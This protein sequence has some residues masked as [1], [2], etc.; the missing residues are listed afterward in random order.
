[1][2]DFAATASNGISTASGVKI[3]RSEFSGR[4]RVRDSM[5]FMLFSWVSATT[6]SLLPPLRRTCLLD[7]ISEPAGV[8]SRLFAPH[9]LRRG[10]SSVLRVGRNHETKKRFTNKEKSKS[11]NR[12]LV[13]SLG[14]QSR[15]E[16]AEADVATTG[17]PLLQRGR[18]K[19]ACL[20]TGFPGWQV[21]GYSRQK[22][23]TL[24]G[25]RR[26]VVGGG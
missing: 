23:K 17:T 18:A 5:P 20:A 6:L 12:I 22:E 19:M 3:S 16:R 21:V 24:R 25:C 9:A 1:M 4:V 15:M 14:W 13:D 11:T 7:S 26:A 10:F 2:V 8:K